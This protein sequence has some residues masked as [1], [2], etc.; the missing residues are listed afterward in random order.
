[1]SKAPSATVFYFVVRWD[2]QCYISY[3]N[4]MSPML[5]YIVMMHG[6]YNFYFFLF[7][8]FFTGSTSAANYCVNWKMLQ[9]PPSFADNMAFCVVFSWPIAA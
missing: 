9:E 8:T 6:N 1:M 2:K 3:Q 4:D 7:S 5:N